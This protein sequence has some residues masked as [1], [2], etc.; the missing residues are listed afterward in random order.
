M[1]DFLPSSYR[2]FLVWLGGV[3]LLI[4]ICHLFF[5]KL[6]FADGNIWLSL[7]WAFYSCHLLSLFLVVSYLRHPI[8]QVERQ[9]YRLQQ[10]IYDKDYVQQSVPVYNELGKNL[11]LL[12]QKLAVFEQKYSHQKSQLDLLLR[13]LSV[14]VLVLDARGQVTLASQSMQLYFPDSQLTGETFVQINKTAELNLLIQEVSDRKVM[15]NQE[16]DIYFPEERTVD[17]IVSPV[18]QGAKLTQ[19]LLLFYDVTHLRRLEQV[20]QDFVSNVSHEL[21]TPVTSIK[22]FAETLLSGAKDDEAVRDQF[23]TII[24]QE[25]QRLQQIVQDILDLSRLEQS[26]SAILEEEF[27]IGELVSDLSASLSGQLFAKELE[28]TC[29][30]NLSLPYLGDRGKL[31]Q[32]LLNLLTNAIRYTDRGGQIRVILS[33]E[34]TD[35]KI[36]VAD[37]GIGIPE[38]ELDRIFERFYR[39]NKGRSRQTGGTGLGLSIVQSLLLA[40]DGRIEVASQVGHGSQFTVYLP[41]TK[42]NESNT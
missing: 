27:T 25:S 1:R 16:I 4:S 26:P 13:H 10:N 21:K 28:F 20:R 42:R 30:D 31:S 32:V 37:T 35:V 39:V 17:V 5:V 24:Y 34:K 22:G 36:E 41:M 15:L 29:V 19:L 9:L 38:E 33:Q 3:L 40:M 14:G 6:P 7:A 2:R 23:L 18:L 12:G 11:T 8:K